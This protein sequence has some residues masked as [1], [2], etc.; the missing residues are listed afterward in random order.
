MKTMIPIQFITEMENI[1]PQHTKEH[2]DIQYATTFWQKSLGLMFKNDFLGKMFFRN[3]KPINLFIHTIF[4][5]FP[6]DII[7][8]NEKNEIIREVK[9]MKPYQIIYVRGVK[10]F[11]EQKSIPNK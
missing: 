10:C 5:R 4:M 7:C 11:V 1:A 2:F 9:N 3:Y 6:I 8:Y